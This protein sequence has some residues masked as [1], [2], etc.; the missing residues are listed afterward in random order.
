MTQGEAFEMNERASTKKE[1]PTTPTKAPVEVSQK[2]K[3]KSFS[4]PLYHNIDGLS[5]PKTKEIQGDD[6][7]CPSFC[8]RCG[9]EFYPTKPEY[10]WEDCCGY[11]CW[12]H[13]DDHKRIV[14]GK[15]VEQLT[16][17]GTLIATFP[18]AVEAAKEMGLKK[19]DS[20]RDCCR[21][22]TKTS[23]GYVWRYKEEA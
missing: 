2:G 4:F 15:P 11:T 12:L 7:L 23:G 9:K 10:A 20:I 6:V 22:K 18:S 13:R 21:G 3:R 8:V 17:K 16:E 19:A 14:N 1:T 5:T